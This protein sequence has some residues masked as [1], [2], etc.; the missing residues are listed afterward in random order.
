MGHGRSFDPERHVCFTTR[1]PKRN[2][3]A[4]RNRWWIN[5]LRLARILRLQD[6]LIGEEADLPTEYGV[7]R[8]RDR[9]TC[10]TP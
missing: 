3:R 4:K 9:S 1:E 7:P 10:S 5:N 2:E 6:F 8:G